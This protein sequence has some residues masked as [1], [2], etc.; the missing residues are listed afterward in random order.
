MH[1]LLARDPIDVEAVENALHAVMQQYESEASAAAQQRLQQGLTR[2]CTAHAQATGSTKY[3][4]ASNFA[5]RIVIGLSD[6]LKRVQVSRYT[7]DLR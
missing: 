1:R 6:A 4:D 5:L 3:Q 7:C 2:L